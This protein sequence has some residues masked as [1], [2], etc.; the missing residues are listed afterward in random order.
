MN[1]RS[2]RIYGGFVLTARIIDN[3]WVYSQPPY[4]REIWAWLYRNAQHKEYNDRGYILKRGQLRTSIKEITEQL[5]WLVGFKKTTYSVDQIKKTLHK[6]RIRSMISTKK[7]QAGMIVTI[8]NYDYFQ[9]PDN[10]D[11]PYAGTTQAP[12]EHQGGT[13]FTYNKNDKNDNI[14]KPVKKSKEVSLQEWEKLKGSLESYLPEWALKESLDLH[15]LDRELVV[16]KDWLSS[17]G[18]T[19]V[20]FFAAFRNWCRSEKNGRKGLRQYR[21]A[22]GQVSSNVN[23]MDL[24]EN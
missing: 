4:I 7:T 2:K 15:K 8:C 18:K 3:S 13:T 21:T 5:S 23:V 11:Y 6:L 1:E 17:C 22:P 19:Y 12:H 20:D 16:F 24:Y 14:G 10:Y 9:N